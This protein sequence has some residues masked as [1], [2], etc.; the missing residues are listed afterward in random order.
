MNK[1][2]VIALISGCVLIA[3]L[4]W[5]IDSPTPSSTKTKP[6]QLISTNWEPM[7]DLNHDDPRALSFVDKLLKTHTSDSV[8]RLN[9][10]S[11]LDSIP[12]K[13]SATYVFI[14]EN[15]GLN[16]SK[17]DDLL[18]LV[19]S[20][21]HLMLSFDYVT[22]NIYSQFFEP[23]AYFW[24][25]SDKLNVSMGDTNLSY[26]SVFQ[27]DTIYSDWYVFDPAAIKDTNHQAFA[28]AMN[29]PIAVESNRGKGTI[30]QHSVPQLF[31]NYQ[32][33]QPNG[34]SHLELLLRRIP[35]DKPIVW[36]EYAH[37]IPPIESIVIEGEANDEGSDKEDNSYLQFIL[38]NSALRWAF[39]LGILV[40]L[41]YVLFRSKRRELVVEG[42]P[43][44]RNMSLAFVE[45]LTSIYLS[46]Q[47]NFGV[48]LM[49]RKNFYRTIN[50]HFHIDMMTDKTRE[51]SIKRLIE[52]SNVDEI[53]LRN[54]LKFIETNKTELVTEARLGELYRYIREF[55]AKTGI[56][57]GTSRFVSGTDEIRLHR[58]LFSGGIGLLL[59]LISCFFGLFQLTKGNGS[60]I[61]FV[62]GG[63]FIV[64]LG[65]RFLAI[66]VVK[67]TSKEFIY[68]RPFYGKKIISLEEKITTSSTRNATHI[69]AENGTIIEI[70][71][72]LLTQLG[73][74][75]LKLFVE[76]HRK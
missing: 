76:H 2:I 57:R 72:F 70:N 46:R 58:S 19:D 17:I 30:I 69:Q 22:S 44:K 63:L 53:E 75:R 9:R 16:D 25:Y 28:F 49:L 13:G 24:E 26:S 73:R 12:H 60:G 21:A 4:V 41:L 47:S 3:T 74:N 51:E 20:G 31:M 15:F 5:M 18:Q 23:N 56:A 11:Q 36:I 7:Y 64:A 27:N 39:I 54:Q 45:T 29:Y 71:H 35:S 65:I 52:K 37:I 33:I 50:R 40:F 42:I 55:Y 10:W 32:V 62:A 34:F 1:R 66:P 14:G 59:G 6:N 61:L 68:F 43:E 48:L 67:I 8:Y 38:R